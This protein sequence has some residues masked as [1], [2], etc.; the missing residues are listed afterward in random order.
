MIPLGPGEELAVSQHA[1]SIAISS[2]A[3]H[4][5]YVARGDGSNRLFLRALDQLHARAIEGT[6][7]ARTPF[8]SPDGEWLGFKL[9]ETLMKVSVT[10]GAP[11]AVANIGPNTKGASWHPDDE[12]VFNYDN[13]AGLSR[14]PVD[15]A[16]PSDLT[17]PSREQREKTHRLPEVLPGGKAVVFTLG[18][19]DMET[20][21]DAKIAALS[22]E[23]GEIRIVLEP[24]YCARYSPTGHLIY[25]RFGAL[26][27]VPFDLATLQVVGVP[28]PVLE[29]VSMNPTKAMPS[30]LSPGRAR[31]STLRAVHA[32]ATSAWCGSTATAVRSHSLKRYV[33]TWGQ[34]S[35]LMD[36][37]WRLRSTEAI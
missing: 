13:F 34:A 35:R 15:G 17:S 31:C 10:G 26:L 20:W 32:Q 36:V 1:P 23:T 11:L 25:A 9:S 14:I 29:G 27:A 16:A 2:D 8:F 21:D 12:I 22:L 18:T 4:I 7:G 30:S 3:G 6:A 33:T 19:A 37:R 5:A 28:L 24:G